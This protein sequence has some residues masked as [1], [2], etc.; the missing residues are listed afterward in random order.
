MSDKNTISFR[1]DSSNTDSLDAIAAALDRDR[2]FVINEAIRNYI[3][4]YQW[5]VTHIEQGIKEADEGKFATDKEV[6]AA[7]RRLKTK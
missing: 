5:Q 7:F 1:T 2:S 6:K 3:D 4:L